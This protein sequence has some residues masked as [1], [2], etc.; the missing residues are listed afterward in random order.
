MIARG[1]DGEIK[2]LNTFQ[3]R[4]RDSLWLGGCIGLSAAL[5]YFF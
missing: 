2:I 5:V 4:T 1:Y 3:V